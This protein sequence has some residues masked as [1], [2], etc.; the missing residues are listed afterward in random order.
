[1][2]EKFINIFEGLKRAHG[3]TYINSAPKNGTKLKFKYDELKHDI[4]K[5][6]DDPINIIT[7]TDS[8]E[9][10]KLTPNKMFS[11]AR[12]YLFTPSHA[13][14]FLS[15]SNKELSSNYYFE[16]VRSNPHLSY[17]KTESLVP[18]P[19]DMP[20]WPARTPIWHCL[21]LPHRTNL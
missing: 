15:I 6:D 14:F 18:R 12:F 9:H 7:E 10:N 3:C 21:Y 1:M 20:M 5:K 4:E 19:T 13:N 2:V 11:F 8:S 17:R 16:M